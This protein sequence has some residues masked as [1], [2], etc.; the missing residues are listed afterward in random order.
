MSSLTVAP[1]PPG[2]APSGRFR[3]LSGHFAAIIIAAG[4]AQMM[5]A[6]EL[7]AVWAF[8]IGGGLQRMVR[9]PHIAA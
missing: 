6:L 8:G 4:F 7:A 3:P 2:A 9:A 5:W 1:L